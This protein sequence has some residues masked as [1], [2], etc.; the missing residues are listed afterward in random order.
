MSGFIFCLKH[1]IGYKKLFTQ[2]TLVQELIEGYVNEDFVK[3][4]DFF[5]VVT[6]DLKMHYQQYFML[7][8]AVLKKSG[9]IFKSS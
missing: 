8:T 2:P 5:I 9:K 7:K 1:D 6:N 3:E 4:L